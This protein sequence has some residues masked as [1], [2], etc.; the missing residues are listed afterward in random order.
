MDDIKNRDNEIN[1]N[2]IYN[3]VL[4]SFLMPTDIDSAKSTKNRIIEILRDKGPSLP[5]QISSQIGISSLFAGAFLS[6]L[7]GENIVKISH[8]KVGGSPL[9]FLPGQE[10]ALEKFYTY[11]PEKSREAFLILKKKKI[12]KDTEQEP[13][14]RVSLRSLKD[15]ASAFS[16]DNELFWRFYSVTKQ[17]IVEMFEPKQA[18][19]EEQKKEEKILV[20]EIK[21]QAKQV[22]EKKEKQL[23]IGLRVQK[24]KPTEK[25]SEK[26]IKKAQQNFLEEVKSFLE[27]QNIEILRIEQLDK[28]KVIARGSLNS[29]E[30]LLAAFNKKRVNEKE[31][32]K[33]SRIASELKIKYYV[34][35]RDSPTKKMIETMQAYK[36][37][38]DISR[39]E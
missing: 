12:L 29:R 11:L 20:K 34:I 3:P 17:E 10:E 24:S 36:N 32:I 13:A 2:K 21:K 6:E 35:T 26:T 31:L 9:Y 27:K 25:K 8:T 22:P 4:F 19:Q 23:D 16:N 30:I 28:R 14:I 39:L 38:L 7:A 1:H 18:Q 15:F 37:L 33:V 5:V